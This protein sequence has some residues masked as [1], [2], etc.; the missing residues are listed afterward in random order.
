MNQLLSKAKPKLNHKLKF[1]RKPRTERD[2]VPHPFWIMVQKEMTDHIRSWRYIVLLALIALT[3]IGSIYS[4]IT[5]LKSGAATEGANTNFLFLKIFTAS[6]GTLPSF[7]TF[8]SFLGPLIG[9]VL[10]FDAVNSERNKGTLSRVMSQPIHRDYFINAKFVAALIMIAII[11]FTLGFLVM[12]FGMI[13]IGY[14]PTLEEF[15]RVIIY[16]IMTVFY[17]GFWLNLSIL[18]SVWFRQAA[19]SALLSISV[20]LFFTVFFGLILNLVAGLIAPTDA[21]NVNQILSYQSTVQNIA[22]I[23]PAQLFDE[24]TMTLLMPNVRALGPLTMQQLV[25]AIPD[26]PLPLGQSILLVWPQ[27]TALIAETMICF[28]L[29]YALFMKQEIRS[30]A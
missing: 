11:F 29:S 12:G 6:D 1:H 9:I 16:L 3:C 21:S 19:T 20:W 7:V 10:G 15:L 17:V 18:F 2:A 24:A 30:R 23:S 4:A 25:G 28:G 22:R 14:P 26:S 13:T 27:L 5:A 8:V